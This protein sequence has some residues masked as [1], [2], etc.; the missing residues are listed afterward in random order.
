M[1]AIIT[2]G[3]H[4]LVACATATGQV[5]LNEFAAATSDRLLLRPPGA[6]PQVGGFTPWHHPS[7]DDSQWRSGDGPFG[8]GDFS[9][10]SIGTD[11]GDDMRNRLA[12]L[13]L[14]TTFNASAGQAGSGLGLELRVRYS[15][16]FIAYLNGVEVARRNMGNPGMFAFH[17]QVAFNVGPGS[18]EE[19]I[20]LGA[21]DSLLTAGPN[22]LSIQLHNAAVTGDDATRLLMQASL[23]IAGGDTLVTETAAWKWFPGAAEPSAGVID[24]GLLQQYLENNG[25]IVP[26]A[27]REFNDSGW[28]LGD[29]PV[30][31][32][33]A[34]PPDYQLGTNLY[35]STYGITPTIYQRIVFTAESGEVASNDPLRVTV[36]YDDA[37]ILYLNGREILR[38][39][40]GI[41]GVP[42]HY[43]ATA[44]SQHNASGDSGDM[45]DLSE[46]VDL[47][48]ASG[49]LLEGDNVL[50]IQLHRS[51]LTSSDA[52]ARV[53][54][55]TTGANGRNL[56]VPQDA[57]RYFV[58]IS[59][60]LVDAGEADDIGPLE[61]PPD[62]ENDWIE[63]HNAGPAPVDLGGWSLTDSVSSPGKWRFPAGTQIP[64]GGYLL[65]LATGLDTG[66][67]HGATYLHTNFQLSASGE[68][69]GL[70]DPNG[71]MADEIPPAFPPQ[72]PLH[73]HGRDGSGDWVY[74][75]TPTPGAANPASGLAS[76]VAEPVFGTAGGFH[77][78]LSLS[79]SCP[80]PG[81]QIRYTLD[82]SEPDAAATLYGSP[83]TISSDRIVRAR[84]F[85]TGHV[86]SATVTHTYLINESSAKRS[87]PA[88]ILGGYATLTFYGPNANNY[89]GPGNGEGV[90]AVKGGAYS[91]GVWNDAGDTGAFHY[92]TLR[93][94]ASEKPATLEYLPLAGEPL[95]TD[96]GLRIAGSSYSR[97][98][99]VLSNNT[100]SRFT[101]NNGAQK[102]SFNVFFR[103]EFG[104][105]PLDYPFFSDNRVTQFE[106]IRLRAGKNDI[107]NPFI[108]DELVRR[109]HVNMG[110]IGSTGGFC[111]L[112]ING[113]FKGY[114][115][116]TER[117]REAFMQ[118]HFRSSEP[119]D[120][121]QVSD[122][123]SGD[124]LHWN[125]MMSYLRGT[126]LSTTAGY[127]GVHDFLDVDNFID[128]LVLLTFAAKWDWPNNNWVAARERSPAGRWRF[129]V[130]DAEGTFGIGSGNNQKIDHNSFTSQLLISDPLTSSN[131]IPSI[132]TLLSAS[133]E[134]N[135][136]FAD[137][138][139]KHLFNGGAMTQPRMTQVFESLRDQINPIMQETIGSPVN[140]TFHNEW[141]VASTRRDTW[142]NQ[143]SARSH[144]PSV[145]APS[146]SH[147]GGN[148]S[149]GHPLS[150]GNPNGSG[151]IYLRLD[152]GDPRAPGGAVN[153]VVYTGPL[154]IT[155]TTTVRARVRSTSGVWSPEVRADFTVG[156]PR[157][158]FMP[159][160]SGDWNV[161]GNWSTWPAAFPNGSGVEVIIPAVTTADRNVNLRAPVTV[162]GI[163]FPLGNS[164]FRNRLR[165]QDLGNVLTF[166]AAEKAWVEVD[167]E[168][169]GYVEIETVAGTHLA[170]P[171]EMRVS[172]HPG[173]PDHGSLRLRANWSG[174]GG[175]I[176]NGIGVAS[177]TGDSKTYTGPTRIDEGV[178]RVTAPASPTQSASVTVDSGGQLRLSSGGT[179]EAPAD[180]VFGGP[181]HLRGEGR[182]AGIPDNQGVGI[183]GALRYDPGGGTN[184]ARLTGPTSLFGPARMHVDGS[185]NHL[186]L[187]GP[188]SG[189]HAL[190]KSG[191]GVL[192]LSGDM[193]DFQASIVVDNGTL[194][195]ATHHDAPVSLGATATLTGH[196]SCGPVTGAGTLLLDG[197][198]LDTPSAAAGRHV[199]FFG[200]PG[201][202]VFADPAATGNALL[203]LDSP[204][205]PGTQL[206]L[207]VKGT[208]DTFHGGWLTPYAA[209]LAASV[210]A[211]AIRVFLPSSAGNPLAVEIAGS[212]WIENSDWTL[213]TVPV[214]TPLGGGHGTARTLELR[215]GTNLPPVGFEA[216]RTLH[217]TNPADLEDPLISGPDADP[218]GSGIKNLV[219]YALGLAPG[220]PLVADRLPTLSVNGDTRVF[221]TPFDPRRDD[222]RYVVEAS[223]D[224]GQWTNAIVLFDSATDFPPD[225]DEYGRISIEDQETGIPRRF[226]RLKIVA[227]PIPD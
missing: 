110:Q 157:P 60:P 188:L 219:A 223:D 198:R 192:K 68:Y 160:A 96:M 73:T 29:G 140:G 113:V 179:A 100:G 70:F 46:T 38:R 194:S 72:H 145:S 134:F 59:E 178:L 5:R 208:G 69:L 101:P 206:D 176:K 136:R 220:E 37:V 218:Y 50:G 163:H 32:E 149:A 181:L 9:G 108:T 156:P 105:R 191:G 141:I 199:L 74:F 152:G 4:L 102:P 155:N 144:W 170:V 66:P 186:E 91:G 195:L 49:L 129:H 26:W 185:A 166:D 135:L 90:M 196:G 211:A 109:I 43:Y 111:T 147:Y 193:A 36:D 126:D 115:N 142:F 214:Q 203:V 182:G 18:D 84:A 27:T 24:H 221:T 33:G 164:I 174:P 57:A 10:V 197:T 85:L 87:L 39:N 125:R 200:Q 124:P 20:P 128:Y 151:T 216:W 169:T 51:S 7:F 162:S 40:I 131:A 190:S 62:S 8:F 64:A 30:G 11:T 94:R 122:F 132:Y 76:R 116:H 71:N 63:L 138:V 184:F 31:V 35:T 61:D 55:R 19:T 97:P 67:A 121:R 201:S 189:P 222:I 14:R 89:N 103:S 137:R 130:W 6:P 47:A 2:C 120:V 139:Q 168:G 44:D 202:P 58:G 28:P 34:D 22:T 92:P 118:Q 133:P 143:L 48:A 146:L 95:R 226:Y 45:A 23:R 148:V 119:W 154:T 1:R 42:S 65:V 172:H 225:T 81:A 227:D 183:L 187:A 171:L 204:P 167:G 180:Y 215:L 106:D 80:T 77:S 213:T 16:G 93:G 88:M 12:S 41:A 205:P 79:L 25:G 86:P 53:T 150:L 159:N 117:L 104:A 82:G 83:I 3:L 158:V 127:L 54:L 209:T 78:S 75:P 207:L 17:D 173:N 21:A 15:D 175:L 177:L 13:Y 165:D 212:W 210:D 114:Y 217:F 99:Y 112:W 123:T 56:V 98:R 224:P 52:I 161:A 153:G 107:T